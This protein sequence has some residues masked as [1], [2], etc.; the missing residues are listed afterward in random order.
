MA[1]AF[2]EADCFVGGSMCEAWHNWF[3]ASVD[4]DPGCNEPD[5]D[6]NDRDPLPL[7]D[8]PFDPSHC[9]DIGRCRLRAR[10]IRQA[11]GAA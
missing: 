3:W 6:G 11:I 4:A 7:T 5:A 9:R 10:A 1:C 8:F 2:V